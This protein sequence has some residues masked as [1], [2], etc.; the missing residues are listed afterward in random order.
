MKLKDIMFTDC[1][2]EF[3]SNEQ[4]RLF[5]GTITFDIIVYG[6]C[7]ERASIIRFYSDGTM[8][9]VLYAAVQNHPVHHHSTIEL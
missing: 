7:Y 3:D 1:Y 5:L 2:V 9:R 4:M 8:P 6:R